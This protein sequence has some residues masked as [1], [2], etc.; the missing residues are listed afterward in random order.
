MSDYTVRFTRRMNR[1][2]RRLKRQGKDLDKLGR[3][4]NMLRHDDLLPS[5]YRDHSLSNRWLG[6]RELHIEPDWLLIYRKDA[7]ELVVLAITTGSHSQVF[8]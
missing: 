4:L 8:S 5:S 6:A 7:S 3:V 1:D 2:V